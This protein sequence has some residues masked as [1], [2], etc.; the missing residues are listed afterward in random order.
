MA[1]TAF[2]QKWLNAVNQKWTNP[3]LTQPYNQEYLTSTPTPLNPYALTSTNTPPPPIEQYKVSLSAF[4]L[5]N[6]TNGTYVFIGASPIQVPWH[7][8][9]PAQQ[10]FN[11]NGINY[12]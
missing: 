11:F 3:S 8:R 2:I 5:G 9:Y 12:F 6:V 1:L 7:T 4:F 10:L